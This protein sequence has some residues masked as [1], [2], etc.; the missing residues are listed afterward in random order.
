MISALNYLYILACDIKGGYL[1]A[2]CHERMYTIA[3]SKICSEAG[4]IMIVNMDLYELKS[5]EASF[6]AKFARVLHGINFRPTK[7]DPGIWLRVGTKADDT[8]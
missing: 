2:G 4:V 1:T 3:G 8:E 6:R 5:S 7:A